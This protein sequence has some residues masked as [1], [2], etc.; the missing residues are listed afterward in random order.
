MKNVLY[1]LFAVIIMIIVIVLLRGNEDNWIC[2]DGNWTK[3]GNPSQPSPTSLC[4]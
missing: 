3:H 2:Q 4:K 1:I